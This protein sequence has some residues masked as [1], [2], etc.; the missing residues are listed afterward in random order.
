[1]G[2]QDADTDGVFWGYFVPGET[3]P[4]PYWYAVPGAFTDKAP[5]LTTGFA[6]WKGKNQNSM[7]CAPLYGGADVSV[8]PQVLTTEGPAAFFETGSNNLYLAWIRRNTNQVWTGAWYVE[9]EPAEVPMA[10]LAGN[11]NYYFVDSTYPDN[12]LIGVEITIDITTDLV[13][14]NGFSIQLNAYSQSSDPYSNNCSFQQYAFE[15]GEGFFFP[16]VNIYPADSN[17]PIIIPAGL[18]FHPPISITEAILPAGSRL[19]IS[20]DYHK[21]LPVNNQMVPGIVKGATLSGLYNS[22]VPI[23]IQPY[24][25]VLINYTNAITGGKI[26]TEDEAPITSFQL[27]IAGFDNGEKAAFTSGAG[28]ITYRAQNNLVAVAGGISAVETSNCLYGVLPAG[29]GNSVTQRFCVNVPAA[30]Q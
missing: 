24:P 18:E 12:C 9:P 1:V 28:T 3:L 8:L 15:L 7:F 22:K 21:P 5:A 11:Y 17:N 30:G 10:G 16:N 4:T 20:I 27:I 13:S 2:W 25:I 19:T 14:T 6:V 29:P 26:T 23:Q